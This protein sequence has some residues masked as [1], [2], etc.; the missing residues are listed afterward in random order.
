MRILENIEIAFVEARDALAHVPNMIRPSWPAGGQELLQRYKEFHRQIKRDLA[1]GSRDESNDYGSGF[2]SF[3]D[4]WYVPESRLSSCGSNS[5]EE[6]VFVLFCI[7]WPVAVVGG[8]VKS[9]QDGGGSSYLPSLDLVDHFESKET[10]VLASRIRQV[11]QDADI[12]IPDKDSLSKQLSTD[13]DTNLCSPPFTVF[14][15][16]FNW[17]D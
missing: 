9:W 2:A 12:A 3:L 17:M 8:G 16:L 1:L 4:S 7:F 11:L 5:G 15:G 6:G 10:V 13:V 14:D